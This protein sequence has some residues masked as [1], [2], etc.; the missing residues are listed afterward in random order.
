MAQFSLISAIGTPLNE[1]EG[2][3]VEG[4]H[5]HL[6]QQHDARIDG[7]LVA[8]TMGLMQLL[9]DKTYHDLVSHSAQWW[10]GKGEVLAGVGDASFARTADRIRRL[11]EVPVDGV[12]VLSPYF[13]TF[14]QAEL[15]DYFRSL[16]D[17][18]HAPLFLYD[19]P[20]R[21]R[22][23]LEIET[24]LALSEHP[25]IAGIK[26]SGDLD[27][28]RRLIKELRGSSFRVIVAHPTQLDALFRE[29]VR[30]H[31][32]GIYSIAPHLS[33]Q[34]ANCAMQGDW[35]LVRSNLTKLSNLLS[36]IQSYGIFLAM[37]AILNWQG[38]PAS[39]APRPFRPLSEDARCRLLAEPSVI[40]AFR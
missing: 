32:D 13:V 10:K 27:Q 26:C 37:T 38:V 1:E 15:I 25:N 8:G 33:K 39:F 17:V 7:I 9:A 18:S 28:T 11:N 19:L 20:Q 30:E 34:I 21:T 31:L 24:V 35:E 5:A 14:S 12:V 3:H 16:A 6:A 4:L 23:N 40:S 29:G 2:L 22:T 36:T